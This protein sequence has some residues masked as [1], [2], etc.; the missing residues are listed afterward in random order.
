VNRQVL[1]CMLAVILLS[2]LAL[3]SCASG[4]SA[5]DYYRL[6]SDVQALRNQFATTQQELVSAKT[7][8]NQVQNENQSLRNALQDA[9]K[10]PAVTSTQP[11]VITVKEET[12]PA[13]RSYYP[14]IIPQQPPYYHPYPYRPHNP[15]YNPDPPYNNP[16]PP[17]Y[18]PGPPEPYFPTPPI[19]PYYPPGNP[20]GTGVYPTHPPTGGTA[21]IRT[22]TDTSGEAYRLWLMKYLDNRGE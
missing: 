15:G 13:Y 8:L 4:P 9:T 19:Y 12:Y 7:A 18:N 20:P 2:T 22:T 6:Q 14:I 10:P 11:I 3:S 17:Y 21:E 1:V 16:Y 5:Q